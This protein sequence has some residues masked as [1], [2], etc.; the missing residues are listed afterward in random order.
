LRKQVPEF[1]PNGGQPPAR[2]SN[3]EANGSSLKIRSPGDRHENRNGP[4]HMIGASHPCAVTVNPDRPQPRG[5]PPTDVGLEAVTDHPAPAGKEHPTPRGR[6]REQ[7]DVRLTNPLRTRNRPP[8]N[9]TGDPTPDDGGQLH[10]GKP[11]RDHADHPPR[12]PQRAKTL[13]NPRTDPNT[14]GRRRY[15]PSSSSTDSGNPHRARTSR[16]NSSRGTSPSPSARTNHSSSSAPSPRSAQNPFAH[17]QNPPARSTR[18]LSKSKSTSRRTTTHAT[19]PKV[20][21]RGHVRS[22]AGATPTGVKM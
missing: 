8:V 17:N 10:V 3:P 5:P 19:E 15:C 18:V 12:T 4:S 20:H 11:V 14:G 6:D 21:W 9:K 16:N 7:P 2:R 13:H 1:R 22:A